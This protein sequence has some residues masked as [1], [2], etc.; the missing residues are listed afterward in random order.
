MCY[1]LRAVL[2]GDSGEGA[3]AGLT[4]L[5]I[6]QQYGTRSVYRNIPPV[7]SR[8]VLYSTLQ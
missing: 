8:P 4:I 7:P 6:P 2:M 5:H 1:A 3:P